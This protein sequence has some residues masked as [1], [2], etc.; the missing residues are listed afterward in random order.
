MPVCVAVPD[1]RARSAEICAAASD[2]AENSAS[3][4]GPEHFLQLWF[5]RSDRAQFGII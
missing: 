1:M 5:D 4:S 2:L 3:E